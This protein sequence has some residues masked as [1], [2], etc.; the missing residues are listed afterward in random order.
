ME[1]V[2]VGQ[3]N[4]QVN[5]MEQLIRNF[6]GRVGVEVYRHTAAVISIPFDVVKM[7]EQMIKARYF[8]IQ[9]VSEIFLDAIQASG[10]DSVQY[11]CDNKICD[12]DGDVSSILE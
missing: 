6:G 10:V 12:W 5:D 11:I 3:F 8:G 1:F 4:Q 7:G 2:F 9:V